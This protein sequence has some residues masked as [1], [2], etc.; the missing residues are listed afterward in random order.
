MSETVIK[1]NIPVGVH[2]FIS[3]KESGITCYSQYEKI[4]EEVTEILGSI[5]D[6][7]NKGE[8]IGTLTHLAEECCD[9]ITACIGM[10]YMI[11]YRKD[12]IEDMM[13]Q[14]LSKNRKRGYLE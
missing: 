6:I 8:T 11:G 12:G 13:R 7:W 9:C 5:Y 1:L 14:V 3:N 10:M 4:E 2:K